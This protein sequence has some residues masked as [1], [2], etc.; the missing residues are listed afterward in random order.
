MAASVPV[1][2][3]DDEKD[4]VEEGCLI[5]REELLLREMGLSTSTSTSA[6]SSS[7]VDVKVGSI[8]SLASFRSIRLLLLALGGSRGSGAS[9]TEDSIKSGTG[10]GTT[11]GSISNVFL[12]L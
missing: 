8:W 3:P 6:S 5:F 11:R 1:P 9:S 10:K 4:A 2:V 7:S 12:E